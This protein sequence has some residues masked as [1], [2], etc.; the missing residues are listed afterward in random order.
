MTNNPKEIKK[1]IDGISLESINDNGF[2]YCIFRY[3]L[4]YCDPQMLNNVY[5]SISKR[6]DKILIP[7]P[8]Y[9]ELEFVNEDILK[10]VRDDID[11]ILNKTKDITQNK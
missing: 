8:K 10:N 6:L 1:I 5:E 4:E 9:T 7:V 11:R 2:K 3:D